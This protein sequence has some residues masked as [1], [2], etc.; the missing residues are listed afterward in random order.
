M[1]YI[2]LRWQQN[3]SIFE[4]MKKINSQQELYIHLASEGDPSAFYSL[5]RDQFADS[6]RSL[7]SEQKSH[8]QA[9]EAV[10]EKAAN[11]YRKFVGQNIE[12]AHDWY[13]AQNGKNA[14]FEVAGPVNVASADMQV[15]QR[16][17]QLILQRS[18]SQLLRKKSGKKG[19]IKARKPVWIFAAGAVVLVGGII[20]GVLFTGSQVSLSYTHSGREY[21]VSF[22]GGLKTASLKDTL[23]L[24]DQ[25]VKDSTTE[26]KA[27]STVVIKEPE[28]KPAPAPVRSRP[29]PPTRPR[30]VQ[31]SPAPVVQQAPPPPP[32]APPTPAPAP[33]PQ[34][35]SEPVPAASAVQNGQS[36][37]SSSTSDFDGL[38]DIPGMR[39][40]PSESE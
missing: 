9:C 36:S 39:K 31:P 1:K 35:R 33:V 13:S 2:L 12:D 10:C 28:P 19:R 27:D 32:P 26:E 40:A 5:F 8:D 22:P 6:Y 29:V 37:Q 30:S 38:L 4:Y 3:V 15:F 21:K 25:E 24:Q 7:R 18:Y 11:L 16:E 23:V 20:A 17:L 34:P 14:D